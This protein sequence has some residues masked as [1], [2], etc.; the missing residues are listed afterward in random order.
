MSWHVLA[1]ATL[2]GV[3]LPLPATLAASVPPEKA[4]Q[5]PA[6]EWLALVDAG[7]YTESWEQM[8]P[9]FRKEVGKRKWK[10]E[11]Q[12]IRRPLG[13]LSE[14]KL[15][16]AEYSRELPGAPE[17]EYVVLRYDT[18]FEHRAAA[19]ETVTLVLGQDLI[20]RVAGYA[21]K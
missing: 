8:A 20:W 1:L 17:G 7:Q 3:V 6:E 13:K 5:A 15:K 18:S 10:T 11:I 4:A 21:V 19:E 12:K 16:A 2:L 14:R 9:H